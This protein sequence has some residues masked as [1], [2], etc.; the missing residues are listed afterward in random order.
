MGVRLQQ[1]DAIPHSLQYISGLHSLILWVVFLVWWGDD[2]DESDD[3][4][5]DDDNDDDEG[6]NDD[7]NDD[8]PSDSDVV[9]IPARL[10]GRVMGKEVNRNL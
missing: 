8:S 10:S 6:D 3:D 5:D 9:F 2:D 7:N 4:D 1:Q